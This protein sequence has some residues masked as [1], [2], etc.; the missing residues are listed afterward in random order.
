MTI[1]L[2]CWAMLRQA[3]AGPSETQIFEPVFRSSASDIFAY[4][5]LVSTTVFSA[6]W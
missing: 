2:T 4:A 3:A 5:D 1:T 6:K